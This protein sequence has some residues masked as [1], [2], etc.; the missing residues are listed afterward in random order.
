M[1]SNIDVSSDLCI[2]CRTSVE[3]ACIGLINKRWHK[4][5]FNCK[6]C[7]KELADSYKAAFYDS[8]DFAIYC[9]TCTK[10]GASKG[11]EKVSQLNQYTYL[12]RVALK[13]LIS[14]LKVKG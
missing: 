11:F 9:S 13:R 6:K 5:C 1:L 7:R 3:E 8:T 4:K 2:S 14:L 10:P 12:L